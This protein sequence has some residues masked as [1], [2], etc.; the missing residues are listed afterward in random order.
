MTVKYNTKWIADRAQE[1]T[2]WASI[3]GYL[4]TAFGVTYFLPI[5]MAAQIMASISAGVVYGFG[6]GTESKNTKNKK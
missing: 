2:T 3:L 4:T 6:F 5:D 1:K